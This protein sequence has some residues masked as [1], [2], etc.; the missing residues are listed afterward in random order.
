MFPSCPP[1]QSFIR[2]SL[3][4]LAKKE[5][6]EGTI[7][8]EIH[9]PFSEKQKVQKNNYNTQ[10]NRYNL[11]A[12]PWNGWHKCMI[13]SFNCTFRILVVRTCTWLCPWHWSQHWPCGTTLITHRLVSISHSLWRGVVL[14]K[15]EDYFVTEL[16]Q[17]LSQDSWES[18]VQELLDGHSWLTGQGQSGQTGLLQGNVSEVLDKPWPN[19][20]PR[21]ILGSAGL[22]R[23]VRHG[24]VVVVVL[25]VISHWTPVEVGVVFAVVTNGG[26]QTV[27]SSHTDVHPLENLGEVL[28]VD[29]TYGTEYKVHR[30]F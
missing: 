14:C 8:A 28:W 1:S 3:A 10:H 27:L 18:W 4:T 7:S 5:R 21:A 6:T 30:L 26:W 2:G 17:A 29:V 15:L 25:R 13:T 23:V 11:K 16:K 22:L 12:M 9:N 24:A 20:R 19:I